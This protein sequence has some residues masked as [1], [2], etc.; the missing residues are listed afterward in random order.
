MA[1]DGNRARADFIWSVTD[2]LRG[3]LKGSQ[4]GRVVLPFT[5]LRRMDCLRRNEADR[6]LSAT[7]GDLASDGAGTV[8]IGDAQ[9]PTIQ[10]EGNPTAADSDETRVGSGE[11][12][13]LPDAPDGLA[14]LLLTVDDETS[15]KAELL[16]AEM[17]DRFVR[18]FPAE[19]V[20]VLDSFEFPSSVRQL[21]DARVLRQVVSRFAELDLSLATVSNEEMGREYEELLRRFTEASPET[22]AEHTSPQD[23]SALTARLLLG[24]D[25]GALTPS[26]PSITVYDPCFGTGGMFS[27]VEDFLHE[28]GSTS[29]ASVSGQEI[30][31]ETYAIARSL[32][33]MRGADPTGILHGDVL[34][35]D[36]HRGEMFD[37]LLAAPPNG[38]DWKRQHDEVTREATELGFDGRFGAGLPRVS[39]SSL[40]FVQH[41]VAHMRPA[42]EGGARAAILVTAGAHCASGC[43]PAQAKRAVRIP[44][45]R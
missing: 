5:V 23:V 44:A 34:T 30:N 8:A 35:D 43:G 3:G 18:E 31:L 39:D 1:G 41:L 42:D 15:L 20:D 40:L 12:T 32:R 9:V 19:V 33:M 22:T 29:E 25:T 36:R 38:V 28:L 6:R 37:Y 10:R 2:L 13:G 7:A 11:S 4:Y 17:V 26:G 45:S 14:G 27:A 16:L 24:P 21:A